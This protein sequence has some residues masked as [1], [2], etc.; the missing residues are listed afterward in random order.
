[1]STRR[2]ACPSCDASLKVATTIP[3]GRKIRCPKCET[4]FPVP[5]EE[6]PD[7]EPVRSKTAITS[8][9]KPV[10]PPEEDEE[11]DEEVEERPARR[12]RRKKAKQG[13]SMAGLLIIAGV[14]LLV[15]TGVTLAIVFWPSKEKNEPSSQLDPEK[16]KEM[17]QKQ[18]DQRKFGRPNMPIPGQPGPG[19]DGSE[20]VAAGKKVFD[21]QKCAGCHALGG[22]GG[23][24]GPD[25]SHVGKD[26]AHTVE[27]IMAYVRNP[28]SQ[29][30][31]SRMPAFD[32]SKINEAELRTLAEYLTSLK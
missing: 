31:R 27:W 8:K 26:P 13:S 10:P 11:P 4:P 14:V 16:M 24:K 7:E 1:M 32:E 6:E 3:A 18:S 17:Y 29:K 12:K 2:L 25:L 30:Q 21:A 20:K 9:R 19:E 15:G 5:E 23:K 28:K 22:V